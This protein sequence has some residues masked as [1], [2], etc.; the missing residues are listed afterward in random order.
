MIVKF[1]KR[2]DCEQVAGVKNDL[3]NFNRSTLIKAYA[4]TAKCCDHGAKSYTIWEKITI[5]MCL[6][7]K[8]KSE[9]MNIA[10]LFGYY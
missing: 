8:S 10:I 3:K 7:L 6:V 1:S 9:F 5:D 4:L 2:E